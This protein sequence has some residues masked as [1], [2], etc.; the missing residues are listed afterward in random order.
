[1]VQS[2]TPI[3]ARAQAILGAEFRQVGESTKYT[4][5]FDTATGRRVML[6]RQVNVIGLFAEK[7]PGGNVLDGGHTQRSQ[8]DA[9]PVRTQRRACKQHR[10]RPETRP[11]M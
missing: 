11:R 5:K 3:A 8:A 7:F 1:M 2:A 10:R 9:G 4:A 6:M